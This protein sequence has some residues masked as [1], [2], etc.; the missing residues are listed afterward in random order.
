MK[1]SKIQT[2]IARNFLTGADLAWPGSGRTV[3][4]VEKGAEAWAGRRLFVK[5]AYHPVHDGKVLENVTY[6]EGVKIG[7]RGGKKTIYAD[8]Y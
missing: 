6:H 8:C 3:K 7:P 4:I 5:R 2:Y 1:A